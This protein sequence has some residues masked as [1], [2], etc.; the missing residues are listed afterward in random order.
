MNTTN[1]SG[2]GAAIVDSIRVL[3]ITRGCSLME[4]LGKNRRDGQIRRVSARRRICKFTPLIVS[5]VVFLRAGLLSR[6]FATAG[7]RHFYL[8]AP[9][10]YHDEVA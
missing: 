9:E 6:T 2:Y 7:N 5:G 10:I 1:Q 3:P 4:M 8:V